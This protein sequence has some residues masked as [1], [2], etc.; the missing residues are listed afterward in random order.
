MPRQVGHLAH[1]VRLAIVGRNFFF[2]VIIESNKARKFSPPSIS[3]LLRFAVLDSNRSAI[4]AQ[5]QTVF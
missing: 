3:I 2:I 1:L 5:T 4:A